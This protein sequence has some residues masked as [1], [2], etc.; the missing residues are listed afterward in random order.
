VSHAAHGI[1]NSNANIFRCCTKILIRLLCE[2]DISEAYFRQ[3]LEQSIA[4]YEAFLREK[5]SNR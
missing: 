1:V 5:Q 4:E 2:K 3:I